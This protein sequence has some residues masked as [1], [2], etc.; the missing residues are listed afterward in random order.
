[1]LNSLFEIYVVFAQN[2]SSWNYAQV[3]II[4]L[5]MVQRPVG[6]HVQI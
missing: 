4:A 6:Y 2:I 1:M 5:I 3:M